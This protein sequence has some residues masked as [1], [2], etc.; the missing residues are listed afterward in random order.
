M[1]LAGTSSP[2]ATAPAASGEQAWS[3]AAWAAALL[4]VDPAGLGGVWVRAA[5]GPVRERWTA[6]L[7]QLLAPGAPVRRLPV[8][9]ADERLLGGLDLAATLQAGRPV[10]QRGLLAEADGGL[11]LV[12]MAE[13]LAAGTAA[14]LATALDTHVVGF[15]RDGL[16]GRW[17]CRLAVVA[18]DEGQGDDPAPAATLTERLALRVDLGALSLREAGEPAA[19]PAQVQQARAR[20]AQVE[21]PELMV[22]ALCAA[23][24]QLGVD[25]LRASV[26]AVRA[27]RAAAALAGRLQAGQDD[28]RLAVALVLGPRAT[29]LPAPAE[30]P[31]DAAP[32]PPPPAPPPADASAQ[33]PCESDPPDGGALEELLVA[34]AQAVVSERWLAALRARERAH[35]GGRVGELSA[36]PRGGRPMGAR[37]GVPRDGARLNLMDTLRAAAPW[38]PLRR[39]EAAQAACTPE[40]AAV[41]ARALG[42]RPAGARLRVRASDLRVSR[43][44]QRAA[45]ATVFILDASGSSALHRLAEAKGAINLLLADCYVR[46]DQVG[47]IAFR[48]ARAEVLLEPTRSLVRARRSLAA[49]PGGGGTP[50]ASALEAALRMAGQVRRAGTAPVLVLLTDG[51]ANIARNGEPGRAAAE[52]DALAAARLLRAQALTSLLVDTSPQPAPAARRLAIEMGATYRALPHAGAA[53]LSA[54]VKA[55]PRP[56]P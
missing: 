28:A 36:T 29:R 9:I 45:T 12:P 11:V 17:P 23:A 54:A 3:E 27:A 4:A 19:T 42:A 53:E 51:R 10:A 18:L 5:A 30:E 37:A 32:P 38:Q 24:L 16:G 34:A 48:G 50:L 33:P 22:R 40:E 47:V 8:H 2:Q 35:A 41:P 6:Q 44:Q 46:R 43:L 20:L 1:S 56:S 39:R 52:A 25:S 21:V 14:R 7:Q 55:L 49:L 13:R 31:Q 26:A 15:E